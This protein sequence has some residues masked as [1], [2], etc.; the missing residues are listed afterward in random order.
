MVL[1]VLFHLLYE[2]RSQ[3]KKNLHYTWEFAIS[4]LSLCVIFFRMPFCPL[5]IIHKKETKFSYIHGW[6]ILSCLLYIKCEELTA[7]TMIHHSWLSIFVHNLRSVLG[8]ILPISKPLFE[9]FGAH[10][11][12]LTLRQV[13]RFTIGR[14][15]KRTIGL[16]FSFDGLQ[17]FRNR[18]FTLL[19]QIL[20]RKFGV[21]KAFYYLCSIIKAISCFGNVSGIGPL[22]ANPVDSFFFVYSYEQAVFIYPF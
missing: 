5:F 19:A 18:I 21:F 14:K 8:I 13:C 9:R 11:Q 16:S 12:P 20:S 1:S 4:F 17:L 22:F 10:L 3:I 7:R 15:H 6:V 2:R